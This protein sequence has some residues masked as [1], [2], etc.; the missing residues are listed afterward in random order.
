MALIDKTKV[1]VTGEL[2]PEKINAVTY[3]LL[4]LIGE[5]D[6]KMAGFSGV[7]VSGG[8][9]LLETGDQLLLE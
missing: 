7:T 8:S 2:R 6:K 1:S 5:L 4:R 3:E 9:L